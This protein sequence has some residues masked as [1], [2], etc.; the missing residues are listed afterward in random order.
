MAQI[1]L[2]LP[3]FPERAITYQTARKIL[4]KN[5]REDIDLATC[6]IG[7]PGVGKTAL[8]EEVAREIKAHLCV[9][10]LSCYD[11][12]ELKGI[13]R[14]VTLAEMRNMHPDRVK[15]GT[16]GL[17]TYYAH[18][19]EFPATNDPDLWIF[20][21]DE[22]NTVAPSTQV[23]IFQATQKRCITGSYQFPKQNRIVLAGNRP[24][25]S[26]AVQP[27][28]SPIISRVNLHEIKISYQ[29]WLAWGTHIHRGIR[30]FI[31][32][33]P[34]YL[35]Y[36]TDE[37][38]KQVQPYA[39][40]RTWDYANTLLK[41]YSTTALAEMVPGTE[42]WTTLELH[43]CGSVG[44]ATVTFHDSSNK[45]LLHYIKEEAAADLEYGGVD[46]A[47]VRRM[48][49]TFEEDKKNGITINPEETQ[50]TRVAI[51]QILTCLPQLDPSHAAVFFRRI[52]AFSPHVV[53]TLTE[54]QEI[55]RELNKIPGFKENLIKLK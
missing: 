28:P 5:L 47:K 46:T 10:P 11:A 27:I 26:E 54:R 19:F 8:V 43:L 50:K 38:I 42:T 23:P 25:D 30:S 17:V 55:A 2:G 33:N 13:P 41:A 37:I 40:P 16:S 18:N 53:P 6:F 36:F 31:S 35:C 9:I 51:M 3:R 39:T 1:N 4:L 22:F 48:V 21:F 14:V 49:Q 52:K 34:G 12:S 29:E 32:N 24:K 15:E 7:P 20:F 44:Y 45:T